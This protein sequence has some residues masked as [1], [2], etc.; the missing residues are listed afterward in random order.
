MWKYLNF[1]IILRAKEDNACPCASESY[2]LSFRL[3]SH[4][5]SVYQK[6][7]QCWLPVAT[8]KWGKMYNVWSPGGASTAPF[9]VL[10]F[11]LSWEW[12]DPP[13]LGLYPSEGGYLTP[14]V[15]VPMHKKITLEL[16]QHHKA[17][18]NYGKKAWHI[19]RFFFT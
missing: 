13:S 3:R 5:L 14:W 19:Y 4:S 1:V 10:M 8:E 18:A 9:C 7:W 6:N 16:D 15:H 17:M 2:C 12:T 11:L